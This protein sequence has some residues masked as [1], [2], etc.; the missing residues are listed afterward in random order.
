MAAVT[1]NPDHQ[2]PV[3]GREGQGRLRQRQAPA[4]RRP[5][6]DGRGA[7]RR[8]ASRSW[9]TASTPGSSRSCTRSASGWRA[10]AASAPRRST[11]PG[12]PPGRFD[13]LL[14]ARPEAL[15]PGRRA[16]AGHRG[17]RRGLRRRGWGRDADQGQR[18]RGQPRPAAVVAGSAEGGCCLTLLPEGEG[19]ARDRRSWE[20]EGLSPIRKRPKPSPSH[21]FAAGPS[22]SLRERGI[23]PELQRRQ[24]RVEPAASRS[25]GG[26]PSSTTRPSSMTTMRSALS[27]VARRWAMTRVVR[28]V[29]ASSSARCTSCSFSASSALVASSSSRIGACGPA[30]GRWP[31]AGAGRRRACVAR[32]P[33]RVSKPCGS[34][35]EEALG[36]GGCGGGVR[37]RRRWRPRGRS[38]CCPRRA[39][40]QRRVLATSAM[41]ARTSRRIGLAQVDAVDQHPAGLRVVEA[42]QQAED[43]AL[44]RAGGPTSATRSPGLTL[45]VKAASGP[46]GRDGRD[47]RSSRCSKAT[48]PRAGC[49]RALAVAGGADARLGAQQF[50]DPLHGPGGLLHVAPG[51]AQGAD[52]A[53]G[54]QTERKTNWKR[55]PG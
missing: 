40:E 6:A 5:H 24:P 52:R 49:G 19:G 27:T 8:P 20:D 25:S 43:R 33:T 2:R 3:L 39:G 7:V 35:L 23:A 21:R 54:H 10:F 22:L 55:V 46:A 29:M 28:P 15:G 9:A 45:Q 41:R 30:R 51:L 13:G 34:A 38:G 53:A 50:G 1:Y 18:L 48:S 17:R 12:S 31:A 4:G 44:A 37:S 26:V 47:R 16:A 11:S 36:L 32:S 14:G 42:Q